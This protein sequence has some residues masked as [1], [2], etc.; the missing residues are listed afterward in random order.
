MRRAAPALAAL[1][2]LLAAAA[3]LA[4][5]LAFPP[6][7]GRVV[8]EA[9]VLDPATEARIER[10]LAEQE[11][12]TGDQVVVATV[13]S[14]QGDTVEDYANRLFRHWQIGQAK[15]DNGVLLL[16]APAERKVRIEVGYG[17]EGVITDAA[18]STIIQ[19]LILPRFRAGDLPG[20]IEAGVRGVLELI[21]P[22][23]GTQSAQGDAWSRPRPQPQSDTPGWV[24]VI[25]LIFAVLVISSFFRGRRRGRPG[26][27]RRYG[28]P[29]V[30]V[31][32][33]GFG[34][35]GGGFA[36]GGGGGFS[37]GGGSSG[38][39]GASGSW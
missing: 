12:A 6:L 37:G 8:D 39:G 27:Y 18:S 2:L 23:P 9:G 15:Q 22:E 35:S 4:A 38:G 33:G 3:A 17:L 34:G 30:I 13:R 20:G 26:T 31:L 25:F 19:S 16:V 10:Q 29:P 14:L 32:P 24:V 1:V 28:G 36:G 21:R 5:D 11:R 7:T